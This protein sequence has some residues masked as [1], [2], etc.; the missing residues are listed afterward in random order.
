MKMLP[1]EK[2]FT[3]IC[4]STKKRCERGLMKQEDFKFLYELPSWADDYGYE[5]E[6]CR[7]VQRRLIRIAEKSPLFRRATPETYFYD[8][9]VPDLH[10][11]DEMSVRAIAKMLP[12]SRANVERCLRE[13]R[14]LPKQMVFAFIAESPRRRCN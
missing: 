6:V 11:V 7:D 3:K 5:R 9:R 12:K 8:P 14:T 2:L 4:D 13:Y 1:H 10:Y